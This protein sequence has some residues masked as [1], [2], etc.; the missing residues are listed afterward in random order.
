MLN[1][2][3]VQKQY[4]K[5]VLAVDV[6]LSNRNHRCFNITCQLLQRSQN[7]FTLTTLKLL[8]AS[9]LLYCTQLQSS[10]LQCAVFLSIMLSTVEQL[11]LCQLIIEPQNS[12]AECSTTKD[13]LKK[14]WMY[15]GVLGK[16][17]PCFVAEY[18][19]FNST[20]NN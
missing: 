10:C 5:V 6:T 12:S 16:T 8:L 13:K 14:P 18:E 1:F 17:Y 2:S 7:T 20:Y 15:S 4:T 11:P 19:S 3:R 9:L